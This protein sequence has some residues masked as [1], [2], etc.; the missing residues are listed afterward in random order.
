M[1]R[2]NGLGRYR[3]RS[4][5]CSTQAKSRA[6]LRARHERQR[7]EGRQR[8]RQHDR[9]RARPAA[10]VRRRERLVQVDVHGVD[11]EIAG[12]N[13][14]DDGVEVGAVAVEVG[15]G[16]V[17]GVGDLDHFRLE[18]PASVR[19][20]QHD[21]GDVGAERGLHR[22]DRHRAVV[23]G[24]D[25][26]HPV[27]HERGGRRICAVRR[28]RHQHD[29][30]LGA[31]RVVRGLDREHAREFA[32]RAG[33]RRQRHRRHAGQ[34]HQVVAEPLHQLERALH[35]LLR[36]QRM[37]VAEARQPRHL[38]VQPRVVLH[39]ARAER[40]E[41]AVDRVVLARQ[42]HV[43]A[44]RLRL[45]ESRQSDRRPCARARRGGSCAS[46]VPA[47]RRRSCRAARA[48]TAAAPRDRARDGRRRS[49]PAASPQ[50]GIGRTADCV[51]GLRAHGDLITSGVKL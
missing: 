35:G 46:A 31:F 20:G 37:D 25:R 47:D 50:A 34:L 3:L 41:P 2:P 8:R 51:H 21:R 23:L 19:I 45:G 17:H 7:R 13:L 9:P 49:R 26:L 24:R 42:A 14:A 36:L 10:A 30:A 18:Q 12:S 5:A 29:V 44:H 22:F 43:V 15:A 48:R 40:I 33:L 1:R 38:L 28:L 27:A 39:R 16:L 11:A 32:M 4:A 6:G